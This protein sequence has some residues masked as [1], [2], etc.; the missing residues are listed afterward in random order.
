[1]DPAILIDDLS[2]L[3]DELARRFEDDARAALEAR[4]KFLVALS[5]GS[6]A[7]NFFPRLA[8]LP[9]DWT[10]IDFF[11]ADERA[12]P[13]SD[14]E[15]NFAVAY[16]LWLKPANVPEPRIHRMY[17]EDPD[18]RHAAKKSAADLEHH[19]GRPPRLDVALLGVG[20]DGHIASLFPG[21]AALEVDDAL[22]IA[23][24]DAP[25]PPPRRLTMTLPILCAGRRVVVAA[26]GDSKADVI[27][28]AL[29]PGSRLP[30][31]RLVQSATNV[32]LLMD[33]AA[34]SKLP[35]VRKQVE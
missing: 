17:G 18:L 31:G 34:A 4:G 12:V 7:W 26:T 23:V 27:A 35:A 16:S 10:R 14:P 2:K 13:P 20:P 5:G 21:H 29:K 25:K 1:M 19:A 24:E 33:T 3:A 6:I 9:L 28:Q 32:D 11:W 30:L 22:V 8:R 15:S